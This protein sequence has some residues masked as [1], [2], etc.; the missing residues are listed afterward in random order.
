MIS[1]YATPSEIHI[2]GNIEIGVNPGIVFASLNQNRPDP[3]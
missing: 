1:G 2:F 3:S